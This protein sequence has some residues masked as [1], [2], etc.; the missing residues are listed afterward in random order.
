MK[1]ESAPLSYIERAQLCTNPSA[2]RLLEL[3]E[4]KQTNLAIAADVTTQEELLSLAE[5]IGSLICV[6]KIHVDILEDYDANFS[7]KLKKIADKQR[8]MIFED[9][10]FADI[11]NVVRQQYQKGIYKIADW[12]DIIT[13]HAIPGP[14]IIEGLKE[15]GLPL[16]RGV[17]LLA[18]MSSSGTLTTP[19][20]AQATVA[21]A[22]DHHDFVIGFIAQRKL[23]EDPC[24]LHLTPGVNLSD[25]QDRLGQQY[26]SPDHAI[27]VQGT[28]VIIVGRGIT[29]ASDPLYAAKT[30]REAGWMA[31]LQRLKKEHDTFLHK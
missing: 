20:Y 10:K 25:R 26:N 21:M 12:A 7:N 13:A 2:C 22:R 19:A 15:V 29:H 6:L 1:N 8:F 5:S 16:G 11:G 28:D 18:E 4:D 9:R 30:Y 14:G 17:L 31:Y 24:F 3:M 23:V 27:R